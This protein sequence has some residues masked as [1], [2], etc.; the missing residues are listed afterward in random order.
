MAAIRTNEEEAASL[1]SL[2]RKVT[3]S[4]TVHSDARSELS[5]AVMAGFS[6]PHR[7]VNDL[8][9]D[10]WKLVMLVLTER[11]E[12]FEGFLSSAAAAT[13]QNADCPVD[14]AAGLQCRLQSDGEPLGLSQNL[15]V[16]H[17]DCC[18]LGED[19]A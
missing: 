14:Y 11:A 3:K 18:R 4:R 10:E 17:S 15:S 13:H 16:L 1:T 7:F 9:G 12:P 2:R 19:L 5:V 6:P 8:L